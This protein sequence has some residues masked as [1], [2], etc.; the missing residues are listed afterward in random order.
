MKRL[1]DTAIENP[2]KKKLSRKV[3]S[4]EQIEVDERK[5]TEITTHG[6]KIYPTNIIKYDGCATYMKDTKKWVCQFRTNKSKHLGRKG[7]T[8]KEEAQAYIKRMNIEGGFGIRNIVYVYKE[9]YYCRLTQNQLMK[10]DVQHLDVVEK[11]SWHANLSCE[12]GSYYATATESITRKHLK[13][14]SIICPPPPK[15]STD[16]INHDTLNNTP[17]NLRVASQSTQC[18]NRNIKST[19]KTGIIGVSLNG[20]SYVASWQEEDRRHTKSFSLTTHGK[21]KALEMAIACRREKES[22]IPAYKLALEE[23]GNKWYFL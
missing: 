5:F 10:F 23:L 13:F 4:K 14:H 11:N 18:I 21:E 8:T 17:S 22:T 12:I 9:E 3:R 15:F 16:H 7:H 2:T 20:N 1:S 19:N 6:I